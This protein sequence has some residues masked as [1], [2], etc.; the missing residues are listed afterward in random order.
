MGRSLGPFFGDFYKDST[1]V[2]SAQHRANLW[3]LVGEDGRALEIVPGSGC[4]APIRLSLLFGGACRHV[5]EHQGATA[6]APTL[7]TEP[8]RR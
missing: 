8:R 5:N 6:S 3:A 2:T 7:P 1:C 4:E